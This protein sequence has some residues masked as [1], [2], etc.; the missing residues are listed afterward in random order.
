LIEGQLAR[1]VQLARGDGEEWPQAAVAVDTE[2]LMVLAAIGV[3]ALAGVALLAIDVRL[4]RAAIAGLDVRDIGADL[5][6]LDAELVAG[7]ARLAEEGHLAE[8]AA[9]VG[10][11]DADAMDADDRVAGAGTRRLRHIDA[12][13]LL[14]LLELDGFHEIHPTHAPFSCNSPAWAV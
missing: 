10:A 6:D 5:D 7:D 4:H 3:T 13:K 11:A 9:E 8:V 2:R 12:A 1:D 14:R